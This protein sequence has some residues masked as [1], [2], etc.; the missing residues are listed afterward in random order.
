MFLIPF[1]HFASLAK[2][3]AGPVYPMLQIAIYF[4]GNLGTLLVLLAL[5]RVPFLGSYFFVVEGF[6]N[7]HI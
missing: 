4:T 3:V 7:L 2:S 1:L 6:G 5:E